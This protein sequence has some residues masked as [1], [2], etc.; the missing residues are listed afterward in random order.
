ME[1]A[2]LAAEDRRDLVRLAVMRHLLKSFCFGIGAL[3][4]LVAATK[5]PSSRRA[6]HRI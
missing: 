5:A 3:H 4:R 1:L 6:P 2:D